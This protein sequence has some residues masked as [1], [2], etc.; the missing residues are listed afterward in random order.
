MKKTYFTLI[1]LV[2]VTF[3][4]NAQELE[5]S[6]LWKVTGNGIDAPS[7]IFGTFHMLCPDDLVIPEKV[8]KAMEQSEQLV[9]ELDFDD[10]QIML[11][12]QQGMMFR[13]GTTAKDYL[14]EEEYKKVSDFFVNKME[15]PFAALV[16]IKPFFLSSMTILYFLDCQ[17][18]SIEQKLTEL[19]G[20]QGIEVV[21]LETVG[22]QLG[23]V[24]SIPL[25][26]AAEMLLL[27]ID[28]ENEMQGMTDELVAK[29]LEEDLLGLQVILDRYMEEEYT[30]INDNLLVNRNRDWIPKIMEIA[31]TQPSFIA[32]GAGH[33]TGEE[34]VIKLLRKEG[35][36]VEPVY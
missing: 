28:D 1:I 16:G 19:A 26:D 13:D 27:S 17:P 10:P 20:K 5:K 6:L 25:E 29:Y 22:E 33:L 32:F 9:L 15:L 11:T 7:Y 18:V 24:D 12:I 30:E 14:S 23:F 31:G 34:G 4:L 36:N 2:S 3:L 21:G 8:E 35:Y